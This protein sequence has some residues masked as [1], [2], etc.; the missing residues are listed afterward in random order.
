MISDRSGATIARPDPLDQPRM[1]EQLL[2]QR[3][4]ARVDHRD[5]LE[6]P[7]QV[8]GVDARHE[9]QPVV[10]EPGQDRLR[11]DVDDVRRRLPQQDQHEAEEPLLVRRQH[12][13]DVV[14]HLEA[15]RV[16]DDDRPLLGLDDA[17]GERGR[18]LAEAVLEL[19]EGQLGT[20]VEYRRDASEKRRARR[21]SR[22]C[23]S[24][25][26]APRWPS[27]AP[28]SSCPL[29]TYIVTWWTNEVP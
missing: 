26:S 18:Q 7:P 9:P 5:D 2:G 10:D 15:E 4:R 27:S 17:H 20:G 8:L 11:G 13:R 6:P 14:G 23:G 21:R 3:P 24:G 19:V 29:P 22:P 25:R 28:R 12:R 1:L 16:D